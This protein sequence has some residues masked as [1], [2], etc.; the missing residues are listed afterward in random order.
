MI[1]R[2]IIQSGL[3]WLWLCFFLPDC[4]A[5]K[6]ITSA[7][8]RIGS[9]LGLTFQQLI[10]SRNTAEAILQTNPYRFSATALGQHHLRVLGKRFNY[11]FGAGPHFGQEKGYGNFTGVSGQAGV[12]LTLTGTTAAIDY[13]PAINIKGGSSYVFHDVAISLRH[14]IIKRKAKPIVDF[15][16]LF[17]DKKKKRWW[18]FWKKKD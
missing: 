11:Y 2:I 4:L 1:Y 6:Y 16:K 7:G 5:Q 10:Y 14:V 15:D 13:K 3:L 12:E 9:D 18:Q 8:I 17:P